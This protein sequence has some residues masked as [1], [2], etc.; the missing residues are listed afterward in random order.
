MVTKPSTTITAHDAEISFR[1][2]VESV[3]DYAIF[4]L[5]PEGR[6]ATWNRSAEVIQ[7]Y[8]AGEIVGKHFSR[9]YI[10]EDVQARKP[11][12]ELETATTTGTG[13]CADS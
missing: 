2:L 13:S 12:Q 6:V 5:D 1:L 8:R 7:G 11:E 3:K 10:P 4:M 9:F